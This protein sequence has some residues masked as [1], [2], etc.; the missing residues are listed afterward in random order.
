MM[1]HKAAWVSV[2]AIGIF[3]S[4]SLFYATGIGQTITHKNADTL[5]DNIHV[6]GQTSM[7]VYG[8]DDNTPREDKAEI[9]IKAPDRVK[10]GDMIV[11]DLSESLGSG[12]DY[13][14]E[15]TPP[16]L[17]TFDNGKIIVCGTGSKNVT[18]TFSIAC[19]LNNDSDI[20]V[21]K[22]KVTGAA[23]PGPPIDP[24]QNVVEKVKDWASDV[25]SPTLRDDAIKLAQSFASVAIIIEQ[26]TFDDSIS[27]IKATATSNRDALGGN[28]EN[29][30]PLLNSLMNELKAMAQL[31]KLVDVTDHA[32]I[33][34]D[35]AKG[36]REFAATLN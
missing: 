27:L 23:A 18:Y 32:P 13:E 29:W 35:V 34:R 14:V 19:A 17:R 1:K 25:T 11:I 15:P 10:V 20:A 24:G 8:Q 4:A 22:V 21:H 6:T 30:T 28:L 12:F 31:G 26:E 36:L 16:G 7:Q 3:L 9:N 33:W 5:Y 2:F